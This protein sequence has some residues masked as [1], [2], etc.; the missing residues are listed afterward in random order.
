M[1]VSSNQ[2]SL[3]L[4]KK[5]GAEQQHRVRKYPARAEERREREQN[6]FQWFSSGKRCRASGQHREREGQDALQ[7][8]APNAEHKAAGSHELPIP[9]ADSI[10]APGQD[11]RNKIRKPRQH[12]SQTGI[13]GMDAVEAGTEQQR[14]NPV[15]N[16]PR[17]Q[18]PDRSY[19]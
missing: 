18:V 7:K 17:F 11:C 19:N 16:F 12:K 13:Q 15:R 2:N 4:T 3:L 5:R 8:P 1:K 10:L 14:G 9:A 6:S